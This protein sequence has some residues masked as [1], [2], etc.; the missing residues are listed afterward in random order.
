QQTF[1]EAK[2]ELVGQFSFAINKL[3]DSQRLDYL[4]QYSMNAL[5]QSSLVNFNI[6][7]VVEY[8]SDIVVRKCHEK[9]AF[10][11][12]SDKLSNQAMG[13]LIALKVPEPIKSKLSCEAKYLIAGQYY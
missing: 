12:P 2:K 9:V 7:E 4:F 3:F 1:E 10:L 6:E 8:L 13:T 11:D 5:K